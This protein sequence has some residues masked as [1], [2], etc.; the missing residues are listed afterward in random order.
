MPRNYGP[1]LPSRTGRY[2]V[3]FGTGRPRKTP[4]LCCTWSEVV[5]RLNQFF[6]VESESAFLGRAIPRTL[7]TGQRC[8]QIVGHY[9]VTKGTNTAYVVPE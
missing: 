1:P 5:N 6:R 3:T 2:F 8:Y 4:V 9:V 7:P